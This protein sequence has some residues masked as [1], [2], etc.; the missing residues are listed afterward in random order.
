MTQMHQ[1]TTRPLKQTNTRYGNMMIFDGDPTIGRALE[2]YGEYCHLEIE[3]LKNLIT[4]ESWVLDIGANIGTHTIALA[5][6]VNRVIAFEPDADNFYVLNANCSLAGCTNVSPTRLAIGD[7]MS[8]GSTTF[9]YGKTSVTGG[10]DFKIAP[11]D[12]LGI[13]QIDVMKI[14]V[15]GDELKVLYGARG[16]LANYKPHLLIEMQD[17]SKYA[18]TYKYLKSFGYN[19][20][21]LPVATYSPDNH[22]GIKENIFGLEHGVINWIA[23]VENITTTLIAVED[24][25]DTIQ[26]MVRRRSEQ[27][28]IA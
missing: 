23:T 16:T 20:Y 2:T 19:I 15:E 24:E 10:N 8:E 3:L 11:V 4:D 1:R 26:K 21:W 14:D 12:M 6:Y 13:P 9:D 22:K 27:S 25:N 28:G 18:D 17:E 5:P 7:L